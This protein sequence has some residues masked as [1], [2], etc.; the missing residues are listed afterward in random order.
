MDNE[1]DYKFA[2][3]VNVNV[4]DHHKRKKDYDKNY[5]D[6]QEC[7]NIKGRKICREQEL[8]IGAW[9]IRRGLF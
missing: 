3:K 6:K 7:G 2:K 5:K 9:N 8:K 4:K 1:K